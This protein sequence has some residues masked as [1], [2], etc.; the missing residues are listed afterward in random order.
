M[1]SLFSIKRCS[2]IQPVDIYQFT[3]LIPD[4]VFEMT[5]KAGPANEGWAH[6]LFSCEV[7]FVNCTLSLVPFESEW[8]IE[9]DTKIAAHIKYACSA[10]NIINGCVL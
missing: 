7:V 6:I 1:P 9:F 5:K 3:F 2:H 4:V 10:G 8:H